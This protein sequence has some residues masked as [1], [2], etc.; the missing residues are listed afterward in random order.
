MRRRAKKPSV[1]FPPGPVRVFPGH[2][3]LLRR[4]GW[5]P[6]LSG[7]VKQYGNI[8]HFTLGGEH[9]F[10]LNNP[11]DIKEALITNHQKLTKGGMARNRRL[12]GDG[13]LTSEGASHARQRRLL[14]PHFHRSRVAEW[15]EAMVA[16]AERI[17]SRWCDG[18]SIDVHREMKHLALVIAAQTL[19][20]ADLDAEAS[21]LTDALNEATKLLDAA[22]SPFADLLDRLP[23]G[24]H[25]R[26]RQAK[27]RL[28]STIDLMLAQRRA[29]GASNNDI[30]SMLLDPE[31]P[32]YA[33]TDKEIRDECLTLLVAGHETSANALTWTWFL[34]SENPQIR[35]QLCE[36]V[37]RVTGNG[38]SAA[39]NFMRLNYVEAAFAEGLRLYPPGWVLDR[40]VQEPFS[41]AGYTLPRGSIVMISPFVLHRDARFFSDPLMYRPERWIGT[42]RMARPKFSSLAFGAGPRGCIGEAFAWLEGVLVIATIARRWTLETDRRHAVEMLPS[43]VLR[44]RHGLYMIP[45]RR[46]ANAIH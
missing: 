28:D 5:I 43:I 24:R 18:V 36:E 17:S 45:H 40:R 27:V 33:M 9:V 42:E 16:A 38:E 31:D 34:L 39:A 21:H 3:W 23:L 29:T 6:F 7:L 11:D 15:G 13:L 41:I 2:G 20:S 8:V 19:F 1:V 46:E 4:K 14:Q 30:L 44:P 26:L 10:F 12:F 32:E 22:N 25:R 35:R 37:D